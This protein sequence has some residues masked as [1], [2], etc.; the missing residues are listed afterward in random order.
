MEKKSIIYNIE[1]WKIIL[2]TAI[3]FHHFY[4]QITGI[5]NSGWVAVEFFFVISG[6]VF[7][8]NLNTKKE[9]LEFAYSKLI[10]FLPLTAVTS[11]GI[12]LCTEFNVQRL[13]AD[14]FLMPLTGLYDNFGFN[15]PDW[16]VAVLFWTLLFYF[17]LLKLLPRNYANLIIGVIT[18]YSLCV[19][20]PP[21]TPK[22]LCLLRGAESV[23][24]GY[25]IGLL[26]KNS[27]IKNN[28]KS[29]GITF[30]E[31]ILITYFCWLSFSFYKITNT[32][33]MIFQMGIL[34]AFLYFKKGYISTLLERNFWGKISKYAMPTF[35]THAF[36][37]IPILKHYLKHNK[38]VITSNPY[39]FTGIGIISSWIL[40]IICYYTIQIPCKKYLR[41]KFY[42]NNKNTNDFTAVDG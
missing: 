26:C 27:P 28:K 40:G 10:L 18:F 38:D 13:Y 32:V 15:G 20:V 5:W 35:L 12:A 24:V 2:T 17:S 29:I 19:S 41:D 7:V 11:I 39:L 30:L 8:L 16:F 33:A 9:I 6:F 3:I 25:F 42:F 4:Y 1:F 34:I 36:L 23:G 22:P 14:L 31:L 37:Y 21:S